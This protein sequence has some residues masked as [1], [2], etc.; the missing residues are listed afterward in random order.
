MKSTPEARILDL[1]AAWVARRDAGLSPAEET[2]LRAWLAAAAAHRAAFT[3]WETAWSRLDAPFAAGRADALGGLLAARAVRR[4]RHRFASVAVIGL[5][6]GIAGLWLHRPSAAPKRIAAV[7][8]VAVLRQPAKE[9]LPDGSVVEFNAG[10]RIRA[11]Y[12]PAARHVILEGGEAHFEVVA[13][14]TRPFFVRAGGVEVRAG[15]TAFPVSLERGGTVAVLATHGRVAV[16]TGGAAGATLG[17]GERVVVGPAPEPAH[18]VPAAER[19]ALLAWRAPR[20]E[21]T[22]ATLAEAVALLNRESAGRGAHFVIADPA[23][24]GVR[25]SGLFRLDNTAALV[26]LLDQGFGIA[27][28]PQPSGEIA[29]RRAR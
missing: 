21:F 24:A 5:F 28:E 16:N 18:P 1:A 22:G 9:V 10:A 12:S 7:Q 26:R 6:L 23:L 29:L 20:V 4:R 17:F 19:D 3:H 8:P 15:G 27:A 13:D 25:I 11:E 14:A 2:T